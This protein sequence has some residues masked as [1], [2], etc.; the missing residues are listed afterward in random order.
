M[1]CYGT[2]HETLSDVCRRGVVRL[3]LVQVAYLQRVDDGRE[4]VDELVEVH[5]RC[6]FARGRRPDV[7]GETEEVVEL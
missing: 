3:V 7:L 2:H 4:P 1:L 5:A 6:V